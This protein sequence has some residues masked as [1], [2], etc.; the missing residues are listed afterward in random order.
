MEKKGATRIT[1][2]VYTAVTLLAVLGAC[3]G[4]LLLSVL[5]V[6]IQIEC[7]LSGCNDAVSMAAYAV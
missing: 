1:A 2:Y 6:V 7:S 4:S 5:P 3:M